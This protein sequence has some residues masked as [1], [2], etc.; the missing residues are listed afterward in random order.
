MNTTMKMIS[1]IIEHLSLVLQGNERER[2]R[3]GELKQAEPQNCATL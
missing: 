1:V 2:E 3:E